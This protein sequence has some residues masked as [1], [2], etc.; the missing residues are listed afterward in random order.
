MG[1]FSLG[2]QS[3]E[4]WPIPA[5]ARDR[6]GYLGEVFIRLIFEGE[7]FFQNRHAMAPSFPFSDKDRAGFDTAWNNDLSVAFS[8]LRDELIEK[9]GCLGIKA[10]VGVV[11]Q[12][13]RNTSTQEIRTKRAWG[14]AR[15]KRSPSL[16]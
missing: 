4:P 1:L 11:L 5:C 14:M 13:L 10:A 7:S 6:A 2:A 3:E 16:A 15:E 9:A 8:G 12:F